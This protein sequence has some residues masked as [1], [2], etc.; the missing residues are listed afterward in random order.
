MDRGRQADLS[1]V[2]D[3]GRC[4]EHCHRLPFVEDLKYGKPRPDITCHGL[5]KTNHVDVVGVMQA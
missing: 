2:V 4:R 3:F 1:I 5:G